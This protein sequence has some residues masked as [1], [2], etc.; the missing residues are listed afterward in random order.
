MQA[1]IET[2]N[3]SDDLEVDTLQKRFSHSKTDFQ[4]HCH[5][6]QLLLRIAG[7]RVFQENSLCTR[8]QNYN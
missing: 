3:I 5:N 4:Q 8:Q 1:V 6:M 2:V 7:S